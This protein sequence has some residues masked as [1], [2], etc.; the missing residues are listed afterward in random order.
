MARKIQAT[1]LQRGWWLA[2]A[3]CLVTTAGCDRPFLRDNLST[4]AVTNTCGD[5]ILQSG[6][7]CDD[8]EANSDTTVDAC[9]TVVARITS[10]LSDR[11][12]SR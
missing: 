5:G 7:E 11:F 10:S 3:C 6:E 2:F 8:G 9:R 1:R 4:K 12:V